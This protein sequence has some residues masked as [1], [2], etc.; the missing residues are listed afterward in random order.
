LD[1][2]AIL[3][4]III[5]KRTTLVKRKNRIMSNQTIVHEHIRQAKT[6]APLKFLILGIALM[7]VGAYYFIFTPNWE[8]LEEV[9]PLGIGLILGLYFLIAHLGK[10]ALPLSK[11]FYRKIEYVINRTSNELEYY[12]ESTNVAR[13]K[14]VLCSLDGVESF[15]F[16][17]ENKTAT[18]RGGRVEQDYIGVS[19]L[20]KASPTGAYYESTTKTYSTTKNILILLP[21]KEEVIITEV[22]ID[23]GQ[24][25][26]ELNK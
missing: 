24:F 20:G 13:N 5:R 21:T 22:G 14:E 1:N 7:G 26:K 23:M 4:D 25:V 16:R 17:T 2:S 19:S 3:I 12:F 18:T 15:D 9:I 11:P 6:F 8:R 10:W